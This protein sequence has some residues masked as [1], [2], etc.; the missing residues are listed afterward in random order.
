VSISPEWFPEPGD[1]IDPAD[2][3]KPKSDLR[4]FFGL[5]KPSEAPG[6]PLWSRAPPPPPPPPVWP[7][8]CPTLAARKAFRLARALRESR[9]LLASLRWYDARLI[10]GQ[11]TILKPARREKSRKLNFYWKYYL[12]A[13]RRV[14]GVVYWQHFFDQDEYRIRHPVWTTLQFRFGFENDPRM[15]F[16]WDPV[17]EYRFKALSAD[18]RITSEALIKLDSQIGAELLEKARE[19]L[20]RDI[21]EETREIFARE[22]AERQARRHAT[23]KSKPKQ[24]APAFES[25]A[26]KEPTVK[27]IAQN[28]LNKLR[29]R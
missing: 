26:A 10:P 18:F 28:F 16:L 23:G 14:C 25:A 13:V 9:M 17:I 24:P 4:D 21:D 5:G 12:E 2:P 1:L 19:Y 20:L 29:Y 6:K 15:K 7:A 8:E 11:N 27:Q 22:E 3:P